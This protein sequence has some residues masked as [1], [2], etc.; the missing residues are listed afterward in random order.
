MRPSGWHHTIASPDAGADYSKKTAVHD[1][2]LQGLATPNTAGG[3][4]PCLANR[5]AR[6]TDVLCAVDKEFRQGAAT[7]GH[8]TVRA[9]ELF[10][11][12]HA[13][14]A[15]RNLNSLVLRGVA[16]KGTT[17]QRNRCFLP[18]SAKHP[19]LDLTS[20][21]MPRSQPCDPRSTN[22]VFAGHS[23]RE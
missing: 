19:S 14:S 12:K 4:P 6:A 21:E 22:G 17:R 23:L 18:A 1:H 2:V 7:V 8:C 20:L 15:Y 5:R 16:G 11:R 3:R 13:I 9:I 10:L